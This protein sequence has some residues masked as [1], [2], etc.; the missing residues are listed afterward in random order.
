MDDLTNE[1]NL[2]P[3]EAAERLKVS[4]KTLSY[5]RQ[6]GR[7]PRFFF[8]DPVKKKSPRYPLSEI[9]ALEK[10]LKSHNE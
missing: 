7:G 8:A 9:V 2:T 10:D 5:W 1:V 4:V 3:T 6:V